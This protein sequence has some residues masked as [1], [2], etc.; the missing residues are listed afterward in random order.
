L[1]VHVQAL[2]AIVDRLVEIDV[3]IKLEKHIEEESLSPRDL[4]KRKA[5]LRKQAWDR[6][7]AHRKRSKGTCPTDPTIP[8]SEE[9][10]L[11]GYCFCNPSGPASP[12]AAEAMEGSNHIVMGWDPLSS[13]SIAIID[14]YISL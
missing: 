2:A 11:A 13:D 3:E 10:L 6:I 9:E 4:K 14:S 5:H 7:K 12:A 1:N 8:V